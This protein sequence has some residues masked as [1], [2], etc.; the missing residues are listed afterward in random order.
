MDFNKKTHYSALT[1]IKKFTL[2]MKND[3]FIM[4]IFTLKKNIA[5]LVS[6]NK[7]IFIFVNKS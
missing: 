7:N 3:T 6:S 4:K 5:D 1:L 2:I